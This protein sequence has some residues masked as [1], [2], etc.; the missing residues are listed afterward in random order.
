MK[1]IPPPIPT[2]HQAIFQQSFIS[3][4]SESR[5]FSIKGYKTARAFRFTYVTT[6]FIIPV[7]TSFHQHSPYIIEDLTD[8]FLAPPTN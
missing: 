4:V 5:N 1:K 7:D 6:F 8:S 3:F 2:I